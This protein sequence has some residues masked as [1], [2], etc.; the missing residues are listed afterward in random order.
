MIRRGSGSVWFCVLPKGN[1]AASLINV[2]H[3]DGDLWC[4]FLNATNVF[5]SDTL[6]WDEAAQ[7]QQW[8][9]KTQVGRVKERQALRSEPETGSVGSMTACQVKEDVQSDEPAFFRSTWASFSSLFLFF[10]PRTSV[11]SS[12]STKTQTQKAERTRPAQQL[13]A[14]SHS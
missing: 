13:T 7:H 14:D 9:E 6:W 3:R 11:F 4:V 5:V 1:Y 10:W 2:K 12:I 8:G